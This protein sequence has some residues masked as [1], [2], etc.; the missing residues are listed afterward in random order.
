MSPRLYNMVIWIK[1]KNK[2][3]RNTYNGDF[4]T[5]P[6][7]QQ[8]YL[9]GSNDRAMRIYGHTHLKLANMHKQY[10]HYEAKLRR[11]KKT[12]FAY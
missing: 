12:I 4:K 9:F 10:F 5:K 6:K 1:W 2:K 3:S 7:T 11:I 8:S